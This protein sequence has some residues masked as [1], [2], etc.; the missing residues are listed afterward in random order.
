MG[1]GRS[2]RWKKSCL[3][4]RV[5]LAIQVLR[6]DSQPPVKA[7]WVAVVSRSESS[8][9]FRGMSDADNEGLERSN[10]AHTLDRH[11][12]MD[13]MLRYPL[14]SLYAL[15]MCTHTCIGDIFAYVLV[16]MQT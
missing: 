9:V 3:D 7:P 5:E 12:E 11:I 1:S 13:S 6:A 14:H 15:A 8:V 10:P 2:L 16:A 4:D